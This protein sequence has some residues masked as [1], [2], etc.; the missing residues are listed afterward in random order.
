[1]SSATESWPARPASTCSSPAS[2][3]RAK[4]FSSLDANRASPSPSDAPR[5]RRRASELVGVTGW[6]FCRASGGGGLSRG[7][8]AGGGC[9]H[10][11]VDRLAT[12]V[13]GDDPAGEVAE[14]DPREADA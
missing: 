3:A 13:H 4:L 10:L 12:A 5:V 6:P 1:M 2:I 9:A 7:A 11:G 8:A 14:G